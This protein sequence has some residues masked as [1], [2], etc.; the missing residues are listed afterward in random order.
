MQ[1]CVAG[2]GKP[3][4][5]VSPF[6]PLWYPLCGALVRC[7]P[8]HKSCIIGPHLLQLLVLRG[9]ILLPLK[10]PCQWLNSEGDKDDRGT[11]ARRI[12]SDGGETSSM[13]AFTTL[14]SFRLLIGTMGVP[15][16]T[17]HPWDGNG[18]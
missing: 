18:M 16:F 8:S 10:D 2:A 5:V 14:R 7:R 3:D 9:V 1:E 4:R 17:W 15:R 13:R 11:R 6:A 12:S